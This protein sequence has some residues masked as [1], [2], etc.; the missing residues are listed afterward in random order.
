MARRCIIHI[1]H[2]KTASTYLQHCLHLNQARLAAHNIWLP[3][4]FTQFGYYDLDALSRQGIVISGNLAPMHALLA[5]GPASMVTEME[6]YLFEAPDLP[7]DHDVLLSSELYFYYRFPTIQ[8]VEAARARG[9][10]P[11]I[12][13]YLQRQDR[14]A[15]SAYLQNVRLHGFAQGVVDF[16]V[17]DR[18]IRY[19]N[20]LH[21]LNRIMPDIPGTQ[22]TLRS[23]APD[24]LQ[25]ADILDDFLTTIG[26][27]LTASGWERPPHASN[28]ALTLEHYELL[29][30]ASLLGRADAADRLRDAETPLTT[31]DRHRSFAY[32][33]RP[34]VEDFL[35]QHFLPGNLAMLDRYMPDASPA[36]R[37]Y[38]TQFDP[39][40]A[41]VA[42]DQAA[43]AQLRAEAFG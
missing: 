2:A 34:H 36:E 24:F 30:A 17:H 3:S 27:S 5:D 1:G 29:R 12:V 23:F 33:Y 19:C 41:P 13:A 42:L 4:H 8:L 25:N 40:P 31:A 9:F 11:H 35:T 22:L 16:L 21:A 26:S 38:W 7:G 15:I 14:A 37:A 39:A 6:R 20:Y 43:M 28:Q 32:Y 18:N 10:E